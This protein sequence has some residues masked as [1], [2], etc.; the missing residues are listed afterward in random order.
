VRH[1]HYRKVAFFYTSLIHAS[2]L[3]NLTHKT[4]I[5]HTHSRRGK[6]D[7]KINASGQ[8]RRTDLN[9]NFF[10]LDYLS[11]LW[12]IIVISARGRPS[13]HTF[14]WPLAG[15]GSPESRH[16]SLPSQV[17]WSSARSSSSVPNPLDNNYT[18][19]L[20]AGPADLPC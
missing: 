10:R 9:I 3:I 11:Q 2:T 20:P 16:Q 18:P 7:R 13:L 14:C 17:K 4:F 15:V 5:I 6:P 8:I 19:S 1:E 12:N